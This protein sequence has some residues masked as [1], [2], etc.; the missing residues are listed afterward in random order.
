VSYWLGSESAYAWVVL[1]TEIHWA[2]LSPPSEIEEQVAAFHRSLTRVVDV[3]AERRLEN[4]RT[5][6]ESIMR[7]IE[8][9]LS[10]VQQ[11]VIIPDGALDY[12][13]FAALR[14]TRA[15]S[16]AFVAAQHD[17]ALS[18]AAWMLN[19]EEVPGDPPGPGRLLLV[20]DPV[21]QADDPRLT[22]IAGAPAAQPSANR[23]LDAQ[24]RQYQRLKYT[25]K[26]ADQILTL[27][28]AADVDQLIGLDAT[29]ERLLSLDLSKYRYIHIAAHGLVD[30]Q[31]PQLSALVL[32]SYD[33]SGKRVDGAVRVA[34]LSLQT[35]RAEV[36]VF[37]AC[38]TALGREVAGEGL[39]GIGSTVLARGARAVVASLW[40]VSDE[41]GAR[42]M[43]EFY[44]HLLHDSMGASAALGAAMRSVLS[45][46]GDADP[47]LWAAFQ[48]SV[49]T[50]T[51]TGNTAT[52][53]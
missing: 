49:V 13:P 28:P 53:R 20:A 29:R 24:T 33:A 9:W 7:P 6:Y 35:L 43:T 2:R 1:P 37:S 12:V 3:P 40:P 16:G 45:R 36:A 42:L 15:G 38:D 4:A 47:A 39:V 51:P 14:V 5:L 23:A 11:W 52:D 19:T 10:G 26:E 32:G 46:D 48:V 41:S 34:D 8:A 21:Y 18:P 22:R 27:F 31:L 44:R 17:V 25:A 50:L 30:A